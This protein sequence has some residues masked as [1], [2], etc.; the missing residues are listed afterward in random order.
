VFLLH[1]QQSFR[2]LDTCILLQGLHLLWS[3]PFFPYEIHPSLHLYLF[4]DHFPEVDPFRR[5]LA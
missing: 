5:L 3:H 2:I 1:E 4:L